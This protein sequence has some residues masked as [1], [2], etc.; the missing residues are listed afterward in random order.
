ME[1]RERSEL[2]WLYDKRGAQSTP[3]SR[4]LARALRETAS[5]LPV[6]WRVNLEPSGQIALTPPQ[7]RDAYLESTEALYWARCQREPAQTRPTTP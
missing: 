5:G 1:E 6:G 2:S 4:E 3:R 7:A